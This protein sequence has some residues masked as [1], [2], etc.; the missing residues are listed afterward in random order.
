[1]VQAVGVAKHR[2]SEHSLR[3]DAALVVL[4]SVGLA[5]VLG[6]VFAD[7]TDSSPSFT[8]TNKIALDEMGMSETDLRQAQQ[9]PIPVDAVRLQGSYLL[10]NSSLVPDRP[11]LTL[12]APYKDA[13]HSGVVAV[14]F[15][16]DRILRLFGRSSTHVTRLVDRRGVALAQPDPSVVTD[17][18][19]DAPRGAGQDLRAVFFHQRAGQRHGV[20]TLGVLW[21]HPRSQGRDRG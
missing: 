13:A 6:S 14:D 8:F 20:G 11:M 19:W 1:M 7:T 16:H 4:A 3:G 9:P 12:A 5:V 18:V 10:R 17:R 2:T 15:R 21:H